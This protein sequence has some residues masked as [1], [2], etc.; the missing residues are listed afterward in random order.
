MAYETLIYE[1]EGN[2]GIVTMNRPDKRNALNLQLMQELVSVF[3]EIDKDK[4]INVA[5]LTGSDKFFC[6]G[7]D[8]SMLDAISSPLASMELTSDVN[9]PTW[10]MEEIQ[11]PIIAAVAGPALGGG[12][13]LA[14]ACDFRIAAENAVFGQPEINVGILPGI[15]G[16]QRLPRLIGMA[17]AKY[18]VF[19][20]E[21]INAQEA[22]RIGLVHKVVP[23][24][25][26]MDEAKKL[27]AKLLEKPPVTL[28]LAKLLMN[29]GR[30]LS[31]G[32][33]LAK[34][35]EIGA[36]L[37]TTE[38]SKEGLRAFLEKRK[39]VFKGK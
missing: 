1:K 20:G 37:L 28:R 32:D 3:Q 39:P 7:A 31:L 21:P 18:M 12:C 15:G 6:A 38:D 9:T 26:L 34:E 11:T 24:E 10:V 16:T 13:E 35:R 5:I 17:W 33:A 4:D 25:S 22:Y 14:Q 27:A 2:M 8:I 36:I 23:V 19:L 30:N 29:K